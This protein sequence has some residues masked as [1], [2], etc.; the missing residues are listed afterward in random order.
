LL[1]RVPRTERVSH[2][3]Y[4]TSVSIFLPTNV[5]GSVKNGERTAGERESRRNGAAHWSEDSLFKKL[6][7]AFFAVGGFGSVLDIL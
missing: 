2:L 4:K 6:Q 5:V 3:G 7:I 1:I